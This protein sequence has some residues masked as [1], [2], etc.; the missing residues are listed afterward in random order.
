VLNTAG[1]F[2]VAGWA[3]LSATG[4]FGTIFAQGGDT[5]SNGGIWLGYDA[6]AGSWSL[7]ASN[8]PAATTWYSASS[9]ANSVSTGAWTYVAGT[10]DASTDT[11]SLY[12][13]GERRRAGVEDALHRWRGL[14]RDAVLPVGYGALAPFRR[15]AMP[16]A[17]CGDRRRRRQRKHQEL[18]ECHDA[19][20][21]FLVA[22]L[23]VEA[24]LPVVVEAEQEGQEDRRRAGGVEVAVDSCAEPGGSDDT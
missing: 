18:Y 7:K 11:L 5:L 8:A 13:N 1:S 20:E 4:N 19:V 22:Q 17:G 3:N 21:Q 10:F 2:T 6:T 14:L 9:A 15:A 24:P 23:P 16:C 12:V